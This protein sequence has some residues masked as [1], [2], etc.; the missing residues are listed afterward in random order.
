EAEGCGTPRALTSF[1]R[2]RRHA[3]I[4]WIDD[5]PRRAVPSIKGIENQMR[6]GSK[7]AGEFRPGDA[8]VEL[9]VPSR[10][11]GRQLLRRDVF[12]FLA[13]EFSRP[14][15]RDSGLVVVRVD[16]LELRVAPR[17]LRR[18]VFC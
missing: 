18:D 2:Q 8:G 9:L 10:V 16:A 17:R 11:G 5:E 1:V 15:E 13:V 6:R 4:R 14:L 12:D 3:A 7:A